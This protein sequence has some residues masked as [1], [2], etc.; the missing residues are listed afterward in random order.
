MDVIKMNIKDN[1]TN[2]LNKYLQNSKTINKVILAEKLGVSN[3]LI[4]HWVKG[5]NIPNVEMFP[6][7]CELFDVTIEEFLGLATSDYS[8]KEKELIKNYRSKSDEVK[9]IIEKMLTE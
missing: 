1:I 3:S 6:T 2:N 8:E 7:I 9:I 5:N 4:T